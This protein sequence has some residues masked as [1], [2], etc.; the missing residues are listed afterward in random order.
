[1]TIG[2]RGVTSRACRDARRDDQEGAFMPDADETT[3]FRPARPRRAFDEIIEQIRALIESGELRP[4]DRLPS[5]RALAE[6][7]AV[8][9]NT[10]R[11]ALRM[12]EISG[13]VV[14]KRGATGGAFI[15][16]A[17]TSTV[18]SSLTDALRLTDVSLA[19]VTDATRRIATVVTRAACETITD[20]DIA[21][22]ETNLKE[23]ARLTEAGEWERKAHVNLEFQRLLAQATGNP[24]LVI[25]MDSLVNVLGAIIA[26]V[27]PLQDD[28]TLRS[29]RRLL[30]RLRERDS[31]GAADEI[32]RYLHRLHGLWLRGVGTDKPDR[33]RSRPGA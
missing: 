23:V 10:V 24:I 33:A 27:G 4:G 31:D 26:R 13:L 17:D 25:M 19:D 21:A 14:L 3:M 9:R 15:A 18:T 12:L 32:E 29:R 8:S 1:M 5:E 22:M 30:K 6:Q 16:H 2:P 7:F 11:E 28:F 20:D